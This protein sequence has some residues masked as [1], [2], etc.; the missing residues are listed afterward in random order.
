VDVV[1]TDL[2]V[3]RRINGNFVVEQI[4][5]GFTFDEL[6]GLTDLQ[7]KVAAGVK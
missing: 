3:L 5:D 6:Q 1:V 4:A 7:L 2:A